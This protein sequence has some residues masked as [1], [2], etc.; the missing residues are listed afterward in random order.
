MLVPDADTDPLLG[1]EAMATELAM[2]PERFR[3]MG[4]FVEFSMTVALTAP[5]IGGDVTGMMVRLTVAG[6]D[7]P[8]GPVAL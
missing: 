5:A 7:V 2:P 3:E 6:D 8:P 1:V 4:L